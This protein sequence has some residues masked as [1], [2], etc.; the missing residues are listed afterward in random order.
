ML[1]AIKKVI[2]KF[3]K[4]NKVYDDVHWMQAQLEKNE[5]MLKRNKMI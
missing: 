4:A 2:S 5:Q 1:K 3:F